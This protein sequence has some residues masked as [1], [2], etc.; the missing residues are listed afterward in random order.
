MYSVVVKF[1]KICAKKPSLAVGLS[2]VMNIGTLIH[3]ISGADCEILV[4]QKPFYASTKCVQEK[5][6]TIKTQ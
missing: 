6:A 3:S 4:K 5:K 2:V 1:S